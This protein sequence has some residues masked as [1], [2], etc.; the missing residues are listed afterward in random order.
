M[1]KFRLSP[2]ETAIVRGVPITVDRA[3]TLTLETPIPHYP[4]P[5]IRNLPETELRIRDL[6]PHRGHRAAMTLQTHLRCPC[7]SV[8]VRRSATHHSC[9]YCGRVWKNEEVPA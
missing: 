2:G 5:G 3:V 4:S 9:Q 8:Y 1:H 6:W 7:G